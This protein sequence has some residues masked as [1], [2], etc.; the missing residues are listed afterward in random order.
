MAWM[1][2]GVTLASFKAVAPGQATITAVGGASCSP[3][4]ACPMYA[5][6]YSIDVTVTL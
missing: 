6:L 5:V 2:S 3:G 1:T 4:Q